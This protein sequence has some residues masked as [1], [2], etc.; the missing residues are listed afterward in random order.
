MLFKKKYMSISFQFEFMTL[1]EGDV[2][3]TTG[4]D[5]FVDLSLS[6]YGI[7]GEGSTIKICIQEVRKTISSDLIGFS[8]FRL[9]VHSPFKFWF[10]LQHS[11]PD[12]EQ[13][14]EALK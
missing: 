13:L 2:Y 11:M 4:K 9:Q 1:L 6:Q 12:L 8:Y 7:G 14:M 5:P 10:Q 3:I